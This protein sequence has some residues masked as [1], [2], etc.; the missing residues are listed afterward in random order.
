MH[1]AGSQHDAFLSYGPIGLKFAP[2]KTSKNP[3]RLI[4]SHFQQSDEAL[5]GV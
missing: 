1:H 5:K 4:D 3:K 2:P